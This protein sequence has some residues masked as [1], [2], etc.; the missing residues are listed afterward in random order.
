[1]WVQR[2]CV[3]NPTHMFDNVRV[4]PTSAAGKVQN[5]EDD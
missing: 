3:V 4:L 1:M 5:D 2:D